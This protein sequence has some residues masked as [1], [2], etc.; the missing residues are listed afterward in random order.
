MV[1]RITTSPEGFKAIATTN[2][3]EIAAIGNE[4]RQIY[5]SAIPS[6]SRRNPNMDLNY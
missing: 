5:G 3:G 6:R 1:N 2:N 4:E